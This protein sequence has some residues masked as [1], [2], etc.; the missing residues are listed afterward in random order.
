VAGHARAHVKI[1]IVTASFNAAATL[2]AALA[3]VAAQDFRDFEHIIVDGGSTDGTLDVIAA[4]KGHRVRFLPGPDRGIYDAMNKGIAA[5]AGDVVGF[6]NADDRY[7]DAHVLSRIANAMND[8][9]VD[10]VHGDLTFVDPSDRRLLRYWK[11]APFAPADFRRGWLPPHPTLYIRRNVFDSVGPFTLDYRAAG[12]I[13]WMMRLFSR[14]LLHAHYIPQVLVEM[15][16][17]GVSNAGLK[18]YLR[19]NRDVWRACTLLG[20]PPATFVLGKIVRKIPQWLN[21]KHAP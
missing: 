3:S 12:D 19:T 6:L 20:I 17:G 5:S 15:D 9:A 21:R 8:P 2:Q 7:A 10:C 1:S 14:P 11:S 4:W 16:A 18:A 13:E